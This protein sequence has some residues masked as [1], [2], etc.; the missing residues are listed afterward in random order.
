MEGEAYRRLLIKSEEENQEVNREKLDQKS[1]NFKSKYINNK[2]F[3]G[4]SSPA[5]KPE[6]NE[7][8]FFK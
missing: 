6:Q 5:T 3:F 1:I 2:Y 8:V 4:T 7:V